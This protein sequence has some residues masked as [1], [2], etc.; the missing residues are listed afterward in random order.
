MLSW[1]SNP[2]IGASGQWNKMTII[3]R[4]S[5]LFNHIDTVARRIYG[6]AKRV[7]FITM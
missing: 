6:W 5:L 3:K 2:E 7:A 1:E 4:S